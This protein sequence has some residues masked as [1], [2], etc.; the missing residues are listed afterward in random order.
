MPAD[1]AVCHTLRGGRGEEE[2]AGPA[3]A[4]LEDGLG[5]VDPGLGIGLQERQ[6][7]QEDSPGVYLELAVVTPG[8]EHDVSV[9]LEWF[10]LDWN[11]CSV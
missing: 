9:R 3:D 2:P 4:E 6:P 5:L 1:V 11:C 8:P 10:S 7:W